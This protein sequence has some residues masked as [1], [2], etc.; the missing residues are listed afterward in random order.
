MVEGV[1]AVGEGQGM[2]GARGDRRHE[3]QREQWFGR[4]VGG[5]G[6]FSIAD[7]FDIKGEADPLCAC[8]NGLFTVRRRTPKVTH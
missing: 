5:G 3:G 7:E 4:G 1:W 2:L 8:V 6:R